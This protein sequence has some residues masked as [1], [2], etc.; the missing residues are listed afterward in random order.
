MMTMGRVANPAEMMIQMV[1]PSC[2][3][4]NWTA[5]LLAQKSAQVVR[6]MSSWCSWRDSW[7]ITRINARCA[8][9]RSPHTKVIGYITCMCPW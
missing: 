9:I 8:L 3:G 5:L 2:D 1:S 4:V 7:I 6:L